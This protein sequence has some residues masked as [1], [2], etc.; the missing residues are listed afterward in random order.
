MG[1]ETVPFNDFLMGEV[2]PSL[3]GRF[4][5]N[6]YKS[7]LA[8]LYNMLPLPTG[9]VRRRPG[10]RHCANLTST[11]LNYRLFHFDSVDGTPY[12]FVTYA[13]KIDIYSMATH[14]FITSLANPYS[15]ADIPAVTY[16]QTQGLFLLFCDGAANYAPI[17]VVNSAKDG[18]GTWSLPAIT[19]TTALANFMVAGYYP[20]AGEFVDGR[21]FV[22]GVPGQRNANMAS[23]IPATYTSAIVDYETF[24]VSTT[25]TA[26]DMI[27]IVQSGMDVP[28][29]WIFGKDQALLVGNKRNVWF[30]V[31]AAPPTPTSFALRSTSEYGASVARPRE[32]IDVMLYVSSDQRTLRSMILNRYRGRYYD[33][34]LTATAHHLTSRGVT[35]FCLGIHPEPVAWMMMDDGSLMS[36]SLLRSDQGASVTARAG[37]AQHQ[38]GGA[39][40]VKAICSVPNATYDEIWMIVSR[41]VGGAT[42][43]S[44][45]Y[46]YLDD[47]NATAIEDSVYYDN[48]ITVTNGAA[49]N[50]ITGLADLNGATVKALGDGAKDAPG[51]TAVNPNGEYQDVSGGQIDVLTAAKKVTVGFGSYYLL[52]TLSPNLPL[53]GVTQGKYRRVEKVW[54]RMY[55]SLGGFVGSQPPKNPPD[56][57]SPLAPMLQERWGAS[58]YGSSP[59]LFSGDAILFQAN[60]ID[61]LGELYLSDSG[62]FPMNLT[63]MMARIGIMET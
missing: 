19:W 62:P 27:Y 5:T 57:L 33:S 53:P 25:P 38:L 58:T 40:I 35:D 1:A 44:L 7:G 17:C 54:A 52:Q 28:T 59:Q 37:I 22:S 31:S 8:K 32:F 39:G 24:A 3:Y 23:S 4:D 11:T 46:L 49:A 47:V 45:E 61:R 13:A 50:I 55:R 6:V 10:T 9:G 18:T 21:L 34:D 26:Q 41:I 56:D 14:A 29:R 60:K 36:A 42:V 48:S 2:S 20:A 12:V 30:E 16:A 43:Y 63:A 51:A 15:D